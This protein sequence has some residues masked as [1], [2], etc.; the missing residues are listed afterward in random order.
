[1]TTMGKSPD[2]PFTKEA[3]AAELRELIFFQASHIAHVA[4]NEAASNFLGFS[5]EIGC[6]SGP[7]QGEAKQI[8]LGRFRV[9]PYLSDAFDYAFQVGRCWN[10]DESADAEV[11]H[12]DYSVTPHACWGEISPY[13]EANSKV[14]HVVDLATARIT[15]DL[16]RDSG[17]LTVRHLA[18]LANMSEAAVRNALSAAKISSP[19]DTEAA[20]EWLKDRK[21]FVPT[22]TEENW[23]ANWTA[24]TNFYL[25]AERLQAGL[26]GVLNDLKLTPET[27]A[28]AA[29]ISVDEI[30]SLLGDAPPIPISIDKLKRLGSVLEADVPHFV[31]QAMEATLRRLG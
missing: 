9:W 14:R 23:A 24:R 8:D 22:R 1:M 5:C 28:S 12:F 10:Y 4:G 27:A 7:S 30:R 21:G 3:M 16:N 6:F 2:P 17:S 19:V 25:S 20:A 11:S 13:H 18:L 29:D 15:L 31:G 26:A